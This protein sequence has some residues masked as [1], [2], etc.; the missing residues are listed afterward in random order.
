MEQGST[1]VTSRKVVK[2]VSKDP[3]KSK[4]DWGSLRNIGSFI[5]KNSKSSSKSVKAPPQVS[6]SGKFNPRIAA[7]EKAVAFQKEL[8]EVRKATGEEISELELKIAS[9]DAVLRRRAVSLQEAEEKI[10]TLE[11]QLSEYIEKV[12]QLQ[13]REKEV[14][15]IVTDH[16]RRPVAGLLRTAFL[17]G[18]GAAV[19]TATANKAS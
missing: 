13:V 7:E 1:T 15:K 10:G 3:T 16:R 6:L 14:E 12:E 18:L 5:R 19:A 2:P 9:R 4:S 17:T 11:A 8:A